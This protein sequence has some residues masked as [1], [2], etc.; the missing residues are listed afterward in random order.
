[1]DLIFPKPKSKV[2]SAKNIFERVQCLETKKFD[3]EKDIKE[4]SSK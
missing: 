2:V 4:E 3:E 1:V